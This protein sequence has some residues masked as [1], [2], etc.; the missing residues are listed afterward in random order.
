[1]QSKKQLLKGVALTLASIAFLAG[2]S[3]AQS[4]SPEDVIAKAKEQL[5]KGI[6]R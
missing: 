5:I 4:E 3:N 2:C 6:T 1:M